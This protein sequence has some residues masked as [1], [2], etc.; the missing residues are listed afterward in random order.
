MKEQEYCLRTLYII[1]NGFDL[2]HQLQTSYDQ[3]GVFLKSN[4]SELYDSLVEF[5]Y[6]PDI[7]NKNYSSTNLW[8]DF[9]ADLSNLDGKEVLEKFSDYAADMSSDDYYRDIGAIQ[10][11]VEWFVD[12]ITSGLFGDFQEFIHQ[13]EYPDHELVGILDIDRNA[14]FLNF[15][16]TN[17]LE[18]YYDIPEANILYIH[19]NI[20]KGD[21]P[22]LGHGIE[23]LELESKVVTIPE[24]LSDEDRERYEDHMND[25]YDLSYDLGEEEVD[26]YYRKSFKD[27]EEI[28]FENSLFFSE[29]DEIEKVIILGH[30]LAEVDRDY[31][32]EV[33]TSVSESTA[34]IVS[35]YGDSEKE[36]HLEVLEEIGIE[37]SNLNLIR[38]DHLLI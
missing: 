13:V 38:L 28:I 25:Q 8:S 37:N 4:N 5:L 29:L 24:N 9:E 12:K 2:H 6:L 1:G 26:K 34:W 36:H 27:T 17:T 3:F 11:E 23:P 22:I 32:Q 30:S 10:R 7:S 21:I 14:V 20:E 33:F 15:N 19:G 18:N 35:Y 31:I 16:Y